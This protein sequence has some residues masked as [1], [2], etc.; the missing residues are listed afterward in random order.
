MVRD[1]TQTVAL[2]RVSN[3][4][5]IIVRNRD[6]VKNLSISPPFC[7]RLDIDWQRYTIKDILCQPMFRGH[8]RKGNRY[9][10]DDIGSPWCSWCASYRWPGLVLL[11]IRPSSTCRLCPSWTVV[12]RIRRHRRGPPRQPRHRLPHRHLRRLRRSSRRR[13]LLRRRRRR[14]R[15]PRSRHPH[16]A[17]LRHPRHHPAGYRCR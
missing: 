6:S 15:R 16:P 12:R 14:Q 2:G 10:C 13:L 17:Q 4:G 9:G 1:N 11:L 7:S 8:S 5:P 3:R